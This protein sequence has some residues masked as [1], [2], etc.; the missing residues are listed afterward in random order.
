MQ[1]GMSACFPRAAYCS[2][3]HT[4]ESASQCPAMKA[5][6]VPKR[7]KPNSHIDMLVPDCGFGDRLNVM[8]DWHHT[9]GIPVVRGQGRRENAR[10]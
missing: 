10:D 1:L 8:H 5:A 9:R 3:R 4:Q 2:D 6:P 7:M